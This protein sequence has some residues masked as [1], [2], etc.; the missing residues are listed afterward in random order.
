MSADI[1]GGKMLT[2]TA[3]RRLEVLKQAGNQ[4]VPRSA[5][6]TQEQLDATA[7]SWFAQLGEGLAGGPSAD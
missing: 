3:Q 6:V 4:Q 1:P 2:P 7:P 5:G